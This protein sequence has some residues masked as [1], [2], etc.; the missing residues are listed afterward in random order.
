MDGVES[1]LRG[2]DVKRKIRVLNTTDWAR[3]M[4]EAKAKH[5]WP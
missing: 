4:K 5:E 2:M 3:V 1:D